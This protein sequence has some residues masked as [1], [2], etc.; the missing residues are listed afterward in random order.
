MLHTGLHDTTRRQRWD[1]GTSG[2][3]QGH[4]HSTA[5]MPE[6]RCSNSWPPR[7]R[8]GIWK[9]FTRF[10]RR[11]RSQLVFETMSAVLRSFYYGACIKTPPVGHQNTAARIASHHNIGQGFGKVEKIHMV[12]ENNPQRAHRLGNVVQRCTLP[13]VL[14]PSIRRWCAQGPQRRRTEIWR[15]RKDSHGL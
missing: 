4:T 3:R 8:T 15:S 5:G 10:R 9:R 14:G 11:I 7:R 6:H 1:G 2:T 12:Q 13:A